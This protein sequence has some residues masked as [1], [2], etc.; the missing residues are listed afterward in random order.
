VAPIL[1]FDPNLMAPVLLYAFA[2]AVFGGID[3]PLGAV[4]GGLL[5]GVLLNLV[6][7]YGGILIPKAGDLRLALALVIIVGVLLFRPGGLFGHA[8]VAR[9]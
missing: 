6:G 9:V 5:L 2:A 3:S 7:A 4:V 8:H 1:P